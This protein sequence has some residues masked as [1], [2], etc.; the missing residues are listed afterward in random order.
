MIALTRE[1]LEMF[2]NKGNVPFDWTTVSEKEVVG[3]VVSKVSSWEME[4]RV[5]QLKESDFQVIK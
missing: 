4:G 3:N 5:H 1:K 2:K